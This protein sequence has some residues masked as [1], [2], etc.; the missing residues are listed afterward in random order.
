[1]KTNKY[2]LES[3]KKQANT[4]KFLGAILF[5]IGTGMFLYTGAKMIDS[6]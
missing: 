3:R 5:I 1:M 4:Y 2:S 6:R